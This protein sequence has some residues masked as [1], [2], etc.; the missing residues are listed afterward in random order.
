[1]DE[2]D[3]KGWFGNSSPSHPYIKA[4][5]QQSPSLHFFYARR[6]ALS[7]LG[8]GWVNLGFCI[9]FIDCNADGSDKT[10]FD[11]IVWSSQRLK[12]TSRHGRRTE[13]SESMWR[14]EVTDDLA[15][16]RHPSE[17]SNRSNRGGGS[18]GGIFLANVVR[19]SCGDG[20]VLLWL[21]VNPRS[22]PKFRRSFRPIEL[23]F[24]QPISRSRG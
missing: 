6:I 21:S 19:I 13:F 14:G 20:P 5:V 24:I 3:L 4:K 9:K 12:E 7:R 11:R 22:G 10:F 17:T 23:E 1:M 16:R 15:Q 2:F 18:L 8:C